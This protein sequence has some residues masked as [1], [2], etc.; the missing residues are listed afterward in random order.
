M[1]EDEARNAERNP[2]PDRPTPA[3]SLLR[4]WDWGLYIWWVLATFIGGDIGGNI[5]AF[6]AG[7]ASLAAARSWIVF[8]AVFGGVIGVVGGLA[9]S[10]VLW[11]YLREP[12][13]GPHPGAL[14]ARTSTFSVRHWIL[15][16]ALGAALGGS[17]GWALY[18]G[19]VH[20]EGWI[21]RWSLFGAVGGFAQ[22]LVLWRTTNHPRTLWWIPAS[23][24]G[25]LVGWALGA[26][27]N[28]NWIQ[29]VDMGTAAY[30]LITG[31]AVVW[32]FGR[33]PTQPPPSE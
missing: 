6:V 16:S 33:P 23:M 31:A 24:V 12:A 28:L 20:L 3:P 11:F 18:G 25:T 29:R 1:S 13:S 21:V 15:A 8:G 10:L 26:A 4:R 7:T 2:D 32:L 19:T 14:G 30:A 27:Q 5:G 9:Q 17:I 22:W